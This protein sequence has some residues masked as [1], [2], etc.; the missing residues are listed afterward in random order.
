MAASLPGRTR[1]EYRQ[2][3]S[4]S[5]GAARGEGR[6][7]LP[8]VRPEFRTSP[9]ER[10]T[11]A[12]RVASRFASCATFRWTATH[13]RLPG[14]TSRSRPDRAPHVGLALAEKS[15]GRAVPRLT[16]MDQSHSS[17][18]THRSTCRDEP[19]LGKFDITAGA[20]LSMSQSCYRSRDFSGASRT[21][22]A[23]RNPGGRGRSGFL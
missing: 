3:R 14:Q 8:G 11:P 21:S 4:V 6:E 17:Q 9:R 18:S 13:R 22:S 2:D 1:L 16:E 10:T 5:G 23:G 19:H 7:V 12:D 15:L 20:N